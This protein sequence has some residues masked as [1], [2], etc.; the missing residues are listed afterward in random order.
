MTLYSI[1]RDW[2]Q[3]I[4]RGPNYRAV[5]SGTAEYLSLTPEQIARALPRKFK[6]EF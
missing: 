6:W 3:L 4:E 5:F 1:G 2:Y